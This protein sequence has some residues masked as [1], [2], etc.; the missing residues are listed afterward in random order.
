[1]TA[2]TAA[3]EVP[4]RFQVSRLV[5]SVWIPQAVS[6]AAELGVADALA[7]GAQRS[8][9]VAA[10]LG[11][12]PGALHRLLRA[13]CVLELTRQEADG[14]FALTATGACLRS[15]APDSVRAWAQLWGREMM[16]RPWGHLADCVRTGEMAPKLLDG[17]EST[18]DYMATHPEEQ[19]IFNRSM[20]E[21]TR[22]IAFALPASY[23]FSRARNVVDVGGGHGALL[24]PLLEA[25]PDLRAS[26]FDVAAC[27]EGA[28]Q[29]F[30]EA[31]LAQR[32]DFVAGDFFERVPPGADLYLLKSVIHD[33][34]DEK[35]RR[36]LVNVRAALRPDARLLLLE[37]PLPERVGPADAN[38][39]GVD[40]NMLVMVGGRERT[41][42][43]YRELLAS[44]GLRVTREVPTLVGMHI[45]EAAA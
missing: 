24:P 44:A 15:D 1:M 42:R 34:D 19:A 27:R 14:R 43:E 37:W 41:V 30:A 21:L 2:P 38:M 18:F 3:P 36:I 22:G 9:D 35:A 25:F 39:V 10:K 6:A 16:W 31:G 8:E 29:L 23:D 28:R 11:V 20:Q 4:P 13:L 40:L 33:W 12:H 45:F 17:F 32:C 26:V 7:A 5:S